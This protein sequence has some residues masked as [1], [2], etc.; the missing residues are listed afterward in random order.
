M[1]IHSIKIKNLLVDVHESKMKTV[2]YC[3]KKFNSRQVKT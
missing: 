1:D 3:K 2:N